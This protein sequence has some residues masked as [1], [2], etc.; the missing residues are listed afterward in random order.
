M[1]RIIIAICAAVLAC[2]WT[3]AQDGRGGMREYKKC[4]LAR[5]EQLD[6]CAG[7]KRWPASDQVDKGDC[8]KC[9]GK[10]EKMDTCVK[11]YWE[12][13]VI[14]PGHPKRHGKKC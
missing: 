8:K 3:P 10:V 6:Y 14:V 12:C 4:D 11:A 7:C 13:T 2:G 1:I 9:K 5:T